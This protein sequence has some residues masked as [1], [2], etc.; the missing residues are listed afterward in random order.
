MSVR[1][2]IYLGNAYLV[3]QA[4]LQYVAASDSFTPWTGATVTVTFATN[5]DG[6]GAVS[7]LTGLALAAVSGAAG[8]Y[9]LVLTAA[10]VGNLAA[11]AG[12]TVYQIVTGGA[13]SEVKTVVP[14]LVATPRFA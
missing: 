4:L 9:F 13:A 1:K 3:R 11:Y 8:S 10:Q 14:L 2:T 12:Q 5:A 6:T 7:G